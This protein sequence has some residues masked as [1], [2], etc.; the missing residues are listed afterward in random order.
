MTPSL[1]DGVDLVMD[2]S[3]SAIA[4]LG[5]GFDLGPMEILAEH[6]EYLDYLTRFARRA[7]VRPYGAAH[8]PHAPPP[9]STLRRGKPA[10]FA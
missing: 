10:A 8:D 5:V 4:E 6:K 7:A 2:D 1:A 9:S 3:G